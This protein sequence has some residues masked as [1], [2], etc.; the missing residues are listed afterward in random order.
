W[1]SVSAEPLSH[2]SDMSHR[3]TSGPGVVC[4]LTDVTERTKVER[5]KSEFVSVVSHE[6]RT[7]LTSLRGALGLMAADKSLVLPERWQRMI[8]IASTNS[9]RLVRLVNDILDI[10]RVESGRTSLSLRQ[11]NSA[12]LVRQSV[13]AM[14]GM[15]DKAQ[16]GLESGES[17]A[18]WLWVDPDRIIQTITNLIS[19]AIKF[20][21]AGSVI[22][23][24]AEHH[25]S[26]A[27]FEIADQGR[28]IPEH[29]ID[30]IFERFQQ[31]DASDSREKGGTGLGLAICKSIAAQH[32]GS[33][34]ARSIVGEGSVFSLTLPALASL[35]PTAGEPPASGP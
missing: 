32:G 6:L 25:G 18:S 31:V 35:E 33:L 17:S 7:P 30:T 22:R 14:Q 15:A 5:L 16:V 2:D 29:L 23:V 3:P 21:P 10:E 8:D 34:S 28:G 27:T 13:E 1:I 24:H 20:S 9:E 19:N 4:T 26:E 12:D 11:S